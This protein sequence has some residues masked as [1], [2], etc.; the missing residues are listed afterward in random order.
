MNYYTMPRIRGN[1]KEKMSFNCDPNNFNRINKAMV[2]W[3]FS[4]ITSITKKKCLLDK[5]RLELQIG[6]TQTRMK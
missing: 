4:T 5:N 2:N 6:K 1:P 3:E